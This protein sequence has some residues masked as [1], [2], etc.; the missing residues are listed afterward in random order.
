M[1]DMFSNCT[2][3]VSLDISN[4][5]TTNVENMNQMFL[6][7]SNLKFLDISGFY[8]EARSDGLLTGVPSSG[9]V[10]VNKRF[11]EKIKRYVPKKWNVVIVD[12]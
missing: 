3:L 9:R 7:C 2:S 12:P 5:D 1:N 10:K 11:A 6:G 8:G 4:F